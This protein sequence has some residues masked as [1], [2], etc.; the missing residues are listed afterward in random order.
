MLEFGRSALV[1]ALPPAKAN[2]TRRKRVGKMARV[3]FFAFCLMRW[4]N[5]VIPEIQI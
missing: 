2:N 1:E 3:W 4:W 5:D